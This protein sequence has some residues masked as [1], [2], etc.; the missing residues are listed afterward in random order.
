MVS[1][2]A[3]SSGH[4][5]TATGP[6]SPFSHVISFVCQ[7]KI[8]HVSLD[9]LC[10]SPPEGFLIRKG[11]GNCHFDF[12]QEILFVDY[13]QARLPPQPSRR[14][15]T[16]SLECPSMDYEAP[17]MPCGCIL[18]LPPHQ[19]ILGPEAAQPGFQAAIAKAAGTPCR[20]TKTGWEDPWELLGLGQPS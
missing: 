4:V 15:D 13:L 16:K 14:L 5:S 11:P 7:A 6:T 17:L 1:T 2:A 20:E 10:I 12:A 8:V 3:G 18:L 19:L 9:G